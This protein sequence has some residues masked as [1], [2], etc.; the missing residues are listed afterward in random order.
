MNLQITLWTGTLFSVSYVTDRGSESDYAVL[1]SMFHVL[2]KNSDGLK[3]RFE[4]REAWARAVMTLL[5]RAAS[6]QSC[7]PSILNGSVFISSVLCACVHAIDYGKQVEQYDSIDTSYIQCSNQFWDQ[8]TR[9]SERN[10]KSSLDLS[11]CVPSVKTY[12]GSRTQ[13]THW[14]TSNHLSIWT[15]VFQWSNRFENTKL[16]SFQK[17]LRCELRAWN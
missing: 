1:L 7:V 15:C 3:L 13:K 6:Q 10:A 16:L 5:S 17:I 9:N 8:H 4:A 14:E 12:S 11:D 2:F